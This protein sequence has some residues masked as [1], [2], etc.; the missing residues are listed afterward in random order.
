MAKEDTTVD[1]EQL[2][3]EAQTKVAENEQ[4]MKGALAM[5]NLRDALKY[6][7]GM[8]EEL[9]KFKMEPKHYYILCTY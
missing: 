1:Q 2:L 8:L 3:D 9:R 7:D 6:A 5:S 4:L